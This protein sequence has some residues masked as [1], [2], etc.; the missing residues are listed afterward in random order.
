MRFQEKIL[1]N[2]YAITVYQSLEKLFK[3]SC[4]HS[5]KLFIWWTI[6]ISIKGLHSAQIM[7]LLTMIINIKIFKH[8]SL[9]YPIY[10]YFI[11]VDFFL[12]CIC[13]YSK[14]KKSCQSGQII[15]NLFIYGS[16]VDNLLPKLSMKLCYMNPYY[17]Y[18]LCFKDVLL[19][20]MVHFVQ[21]HVHQTA[22]DHVI[23]KQETAYQ[24]VQ[25]GGLVKNVNRVKK[26]NIFL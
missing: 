18:L 22:M 12:S 23:L 4:G 20:I 17:I 3:T 24:V 1:T 7:L 21:Y 14:E 9:A 15:Q 13:Q 11:V 6:D 19:H 16:S 25:K 2:I 5:M 8:S 26:L 10:I